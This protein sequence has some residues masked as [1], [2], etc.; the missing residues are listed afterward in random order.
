MFV[1]F[2]VA[3]FQTS[4]AKLGTRILRPNDIWKFALPL[5]RSQIL[6]NDYV[7]LRSAVDPC[8]AWSGWG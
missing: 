5:S 1:N 3:F 7:A 2:W 6:D 8:N 4:P